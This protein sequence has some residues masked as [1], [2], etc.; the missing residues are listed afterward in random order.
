M[1]T[2]KA[3]EPDEAQRTNGNA[4]APNVATLPVNRNNAT[5]DTSLA[6]NLDTYFS[7]E[8]IRI[9]ENVSS[10]YLFALKFSL[11]YNGPNV[12]RKDSVFVHYG[13]LLVQVF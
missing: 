9:P 1:S 6:P 10:F 5:E 7:D 11:I 13:P 12:H 8:K 2:N 3:F 4:A